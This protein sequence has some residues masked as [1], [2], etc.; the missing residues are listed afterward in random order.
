MALAGASILADAI[1]G[2]P[3]T[4]SKP[5]GVQAIVDEI[6]DY[7]DTVQGS[8]G[9][10][11]IF[12][13]NRPAMVGILMSQDPVDNSSWVANFA[14]AWEAGVSGAL[15]TPGTVSNG[16]WTSSGV[17]VLT[18]GSGAAAITN[19]SAAKAILESMLMSVGPTMG[20]PMPMAEAVHEAT[21]SFIFNCI[22]VATGGSPVPVP[23]S[24]M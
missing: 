12:A 7:M 9:S 17:D 2:I 10:P 11:G 16:A 8:G 5:S 18:P 21:K 6:G 23:T 15:I 20:A 19:I 3:R 22:G 4:T 13:L 24:A 1:L 14:N